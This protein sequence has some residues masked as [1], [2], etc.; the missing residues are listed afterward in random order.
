MEIVDFDIAPRGVSVRA[1]RF[2]GSD[3]PSEYHLILQPTGNE[4]AAE[5]LAALEDAYREAINKLGLEGGTAV[6]RRFFYGRSPAPEAWLESHPFS[7]INPTDEPCAVS[8]VQQPPG[9]DAHVALWAYH[10]KDGN[11]PLDKT[12]EANSLVLRRRSLI[13]HWTVGLAGPADG[14]S[15]DQTRSIF[16]E[17]DRYLAGRGMKLADQVIRTWLFVPEIDVNYPGLVTARKDFFTTHGLTPET[18]FI[19]STGI[20]DARD[21]E[22]AGVMMDVYAVS[23]VRRE[24]IR[25]LSAPDHLSPTHI[26]GVTFERG[27]SVS[28]RDRKQVI[29]SGTASINN[30]GEIMYP[31][32][33]LRQLDRTMENIASLLAGAGATLADMAVMI[34]YVRNPDDYAAVCRAMRKRFDGVPLITVYGSVCRPGWLVEVEGIALIPG[35]DPQLPS[36]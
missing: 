32:D 3:G 20:G 35:T 9:P 13:H 14:N 29:I 28:Y 11:G 26:Y 1:S 34:V 23:G 2:S 16:E 17:Y 22:G 31:G 36:F 6:W 24:Q 7:S 10:I 5:Q 19:A 4:G 12:R 8:R 21:G 15:A 27:T 25:F 18:H 30:R 33:V